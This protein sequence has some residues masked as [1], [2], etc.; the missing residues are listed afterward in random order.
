[1]IDLAG[2]TKRV[3]VVDRVSGGSSELLAALRDTG[4]ECAEVNAA[5]E[6]SAFLIR[7][8][9]LKVNIDLVLFAS[10]VPSHQGESFVR[11]LK[12]DSRFDLIPVV[13]AEVPGAICTVPSSSLYHIAKSDGLLATIAGLLKLHASGATKAAA[14]PDETA[15]GPIDIL[16]AEDNDVN[17]LVIAQFLDTTP[18]SYAIVGNGR[19]A[20]HSFRHLQPKLIL[21]DISMPEMNGKQ[22]TASIRALEHATG[23]HVPIVALTAHALNGDREECLACGMDYY[24]SKPIKFGELYEIFER[25]MGVP[26]SKAAA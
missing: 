23:S 7:A 1:M 21:M 12:S 9:E 14:G 3:L 8:N 15:A 22:A 13:L 5:S 11:A 16:V 4:I 10:S 6:A 18:Y 19:R 26:A 20:V 25:H 2:E 17:Q 24:V